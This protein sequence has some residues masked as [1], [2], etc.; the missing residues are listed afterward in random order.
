[1]LAILLNHLQLRF[2]S[3]GG[4]VD[5]ERHS[6]NIIFKFVLDKLLEKYNDL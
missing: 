3:V 6:F 2:D 1:M 4:L 5:L